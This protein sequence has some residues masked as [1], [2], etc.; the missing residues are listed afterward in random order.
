MKELQED[1]RCYL[2]FSDEDVFKG[3]AIPEETSAIQTE[4][5]DPQSAMSTPVSTPEEEDTAGMGR[6]S[7]AEK[8]PQNKFPGWEKVIHPS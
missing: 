1:M 2:T 5:D 8:R 3:I 7:I 4:E 6:E